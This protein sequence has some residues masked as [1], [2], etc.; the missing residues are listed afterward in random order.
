MKNFSENSFASDMTQV[1]FHVCN[2]FDDVDDIYWAQ[3]LSFTSVLNEHAP[4][5]SRHINKPQVPYINSELR[6]AMHQRNM[7]RNKYF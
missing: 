2:V 6:K 5:K 4:L 7:W 3:N 1:P